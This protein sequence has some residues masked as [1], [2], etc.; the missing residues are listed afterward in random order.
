MVSDRVVWSVPMTG[1]EKRDARDGRLSLTQCSSVNLLPDQN[2]VLPLNLD[3]NEGV[4][5][6]A[7]VVRAAV[8]ED[9]AY[10][11]EVPGPLE[12]RA[13]RVPGGSAPFQGS[14]QQ[15]HRVPG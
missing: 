7:A 8:I 3:Q 4:L 12:L 6:Q 9:A 10:P 15:H 11:G 2:P 1:H 14:L 5:G 13:N